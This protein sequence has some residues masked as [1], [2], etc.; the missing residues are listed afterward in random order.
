MIYTVLQS[1]IDQYKLMV[2]KCF[3][4]QSPDGGEDLVPASVVEFRLVKRVFLYEAILRSTLNELV[5]PREQSIHSV[6]FSKVFIFQKE[7]G[8]DV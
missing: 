1:F 5:Q 8:K 2:G 4:C 3:F 7:L 6:F